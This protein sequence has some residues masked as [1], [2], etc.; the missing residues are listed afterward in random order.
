MVKKL[1]YYIVIPTTA[2]N[3]AISGLA[4]LMVK[5]SKV[6]KLKQKIGG[7][8]QIVGVLL[9]HIEGRKTIMQSELEN[10]L[11]TEY[12]NLVFKSLLNKSIKFSES[13]TFYESILQYD[14][15]GKSA[16]QFGDFVKEFLA[17]IKKIE[18]TNNLEEVA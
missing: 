5:I 2:D 1:I 17:R 10:T 14:K 11:R 8:I 16:K 18:Q 13:P 7:D 3:Y 15:N 12:K 6:K 4:D 9:N